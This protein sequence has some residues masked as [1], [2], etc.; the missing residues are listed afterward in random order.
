MNVNMKTSISFLGLCKFVD[1]GRQDHGC[2][3]NV[4]IQ[5]LD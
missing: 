3:S 4:Q 1:A 2:T 5:L